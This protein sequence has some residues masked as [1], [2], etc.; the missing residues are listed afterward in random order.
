MERLEYIEKKPVFPHVR[1]EEKIG[2][3]LSREVQD[4]VIFAI[5]LEDRYIFIFLTRQGVRVSEARALKIKDVDS[6]KGH[7]VMRR[8]F[9]ARVLTERTKTRK[10]DERQINPEILPMMKRL[11]NRRFPDEFVFVNPRTG[12][13]YGEKTLNAIWN[14]ACA[15][16]GVDLRLYNGSRHSLASQA[17]VAGAPLQ[18]IAGVL[19]HLDLRSSRKY[20]VSRVAGQMIVFESIA[21][22]NNTTM[23]KRQQSVSGSDND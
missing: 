18:A 14:K 6:E 12:R 20:D 9:S 16:V 22:A 15:A 1:V 21:E 7:L 11:C 19:G 2:S 23:L 13:P 10:E 17:S 8:T 3:W 4:K 5:P